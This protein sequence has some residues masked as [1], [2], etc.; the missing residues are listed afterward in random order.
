M[1]KYSSISEVQKDYP[2]VDENML[3]QYEKWF[4]ECS[5]NGLNSKFK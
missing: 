2:F 1:T 4:S 5:L 3:S